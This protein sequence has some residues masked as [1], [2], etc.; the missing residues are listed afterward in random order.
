M[1]DEWMPVLRWRMS[2]AQFHEL[3][4]NAAYKYE[5]F[6]GHAHLS[7]R[8]KHYH[9]RL[10]LSEA[11]LDALSASPASEASVRHVASTDWADLEAL[12]QAAFHGVEPFAGLDDAMREQAAK[13]CLERTRTGGDGP[14]I[15]QASFVAEH[16]GRLVGA[17]LI[18]LLPAG[19]PCDW[20]SYYWREAPA[21]D[22]LLGR[23]G[24]AHLTWIFVSPWSKGHGLGTRL[25]DDAARAL[26]KLGFSELFSTFLLGNDSSMLWHWRSGFEL[27]PYPGSMRLMQERRQLRTTPRS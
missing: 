20:D 26:A 10:D 2:I 17:I 24:R 8:P 19:D 1:C 14:W 25:L 3:P 4:R 22:A 12:F 15:D 7:P 13:K 5:Y 23:L 18:T 16:D 27:L 11:R 6:G 21:E 9:A